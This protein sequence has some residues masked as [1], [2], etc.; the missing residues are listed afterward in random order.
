MGLLNVHTREISEVLSDTGVEP[1]AILSH[2]WSNEEVSFEDFQFLPKGLLTAKKSYTRIDY[3]CR[4]AEANRTA[5]FG[6]MR[7]SLN[8]MLPPFLCIAGQAQRLIN[9]RENCCIDKRSSAEPSEAIS[10]M[11]RWYKDDAV[12]YAYFADAQAHDNLDRLH[13]ELTN[14]R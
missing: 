9:E 1:Y 13:T 11:F 5:R 3:Y 4:Q 12:C 14:S 6:P 2:T 7:T 8:P 10:S